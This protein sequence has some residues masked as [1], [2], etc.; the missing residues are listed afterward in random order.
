MACN[1]EPYRLVLIA[2]GPIMLDVQRLAE[3]GGMQEP[4]SSY[5][6]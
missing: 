1:R 6:N 3:Q 4:M 5:R 2:L